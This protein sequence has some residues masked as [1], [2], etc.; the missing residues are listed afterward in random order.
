MRLHWFSPLPPDRTEI[1]RSAVA[2]VEALA[3]RH[4]VTVWTD[5]PRGDVRAPAGVTVRAFRANGASL[6]EIARGDGAIFHL[7][8]NRRFHEWIWRVSRQVAGIVVVHDPTMQHFFREISGPAAYAAL[9]AEAHGADGLEAAARHLRGETSLLDLARAFPLT[10]AALHNALGA[11]IHWEGAL[12]DRAVPVR[13]LAYPHRAR[14]HPPRPRPIGAGKTAR[15]AMFGY[16][17]LNRRVVEVL[18][19]MPGLAQLDRVRLDIYGPTDFPDLPG[20]IAARGLAAHVTLHGFT[21][22]E[23][24]DAV[25]READFVINLRRPTMGEMSA[26]QMRAWDHSLPTLVSRAGWYATIPE[27]AAVFAH[28]SDPRRE[29]DDIRG[30][31]AAFLD[32]PAPYAAMGA[33]GRRILEERHGM[34]QY[35]SGIAELCAEAPRLGALWAQDYLADRVGHLTRGWRRN[36]AQLAATAETL[37]EMFGS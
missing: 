32:D 25:L 29:R 17:G 36:D 34:E 28:P 21:P 9:M 7:G 20:A 4:E 14:A 35:V 22:P 18:D 16:L 33:A 24:L 30:H 3:Q 27:H 5:G 37:V 1:A 2:I 31:I 19:A 12:R 13:C 23:R 26:V 8:N 15:L 10:P 6:G 11:V